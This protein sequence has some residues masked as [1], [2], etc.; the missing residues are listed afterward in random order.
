M[1]LHGLEIVA[2]ILSLAQSPREMGFAL[3][4]QLACVCD[5]ASKAEGRMLVAI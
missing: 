2:S 1:G 5:W 3:R 4:D